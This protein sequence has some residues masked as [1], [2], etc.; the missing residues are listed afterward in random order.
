MGLH[1]GRVL[2]GRGIGGVDQ[3]RRL[4]QRLLGIALP[5]MGRRVVVRRLLRLLAKRV[6]AVAALRR[7]VLDQAFQPLG[8]VARDLE[9]FRHDDG[10]RLTEIGDLLHP[11]VRRF[12][13][14]ALLRVSEKGVVVGDDLD[15][16]GH[17]LDRR[18]VER[19]DLPRADRRADQHAIGDVA[20]LILGCISRL[21][22]HLERSV[23]AVERLADDVLYARVE[24]AVGDGL[25]HPE[26]VEILGAEPEHHFSPVRVRRL[27]ISV[28]RA[29]GILKSL[30]P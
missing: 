5:R 9:A 16:A 1:R 14:A 6:E 12:G 20:Q 7:L 28:R 15:H 17:G 4:A 11:L 2:A 19:L 13:L 25:I 22:R 18:G 24:Q 29:S 26:A 27:A 10:D 3:H 30:E 8:G 21:A 23:N